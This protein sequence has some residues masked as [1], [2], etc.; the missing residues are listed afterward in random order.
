VK[1]L[2]NHRTIVWDYHVGE[3]TIYHIERETHDVLVANGAPAETY[4]DDGNR[5]LFR[6]ANSGW[7]LPPQEPFAPVL[8]GGPIVDAVWRRL[9]DLAPPRT[10]PA[11]TRNSDLH[12]LVDGRRVDAVHRLG[13]AWT[14]RLASVPDALRIVSRSC[15]QD[16][17]G[18]ARDPRMLGVAVRRVLVH[19]AARCR[20]LEAEDGR[21]KDGF[22]GF[23]ADDGF[24]WTDGDAGLPAGLFDGLS[25]AFDLVLHIG[26]TTNYRE[27][28]AVSLAA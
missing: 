9:L 6:N 4:R 12:L 18:L 11:L 13:E 20:A 26:E 10:C 27:A 17:L 25:G 2:V 16:E 3:V 5:S 24:R 28:G 23:E 1:F 15:A 22:H 7:G 8:T 19:Q 14:F 21:L